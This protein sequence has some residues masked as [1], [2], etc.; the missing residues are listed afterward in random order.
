MSQKEEEDSRLKEEAERLKQ[1]REKHFQKEEAERLERK[2]VM[3]SKVQFRVNMGSFSSSVLLIFFI[4]LSPASASRGDYE[5]NKTLGHFR[6][7]DNQGE[8]T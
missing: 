3:C 2:K 8:N 5:A 7:G 1:E 6:K 4:P